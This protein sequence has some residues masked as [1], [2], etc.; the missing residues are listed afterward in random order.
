[1][2]IGKY[3]RKLNFLLLN[4]KG[5]ALVLVAFF[6]FVIMGIAAITVDAGS[7]YKTRREMVNAADAAALAGA[8]AYLES[9]GDPSADATSAA[10]TFASNNGAESGLITPVIKT[11]VYNGSPRLVIEVTAGKNNKHSFAQ[12]IGLGDNMDVKAKATATWGFIKE[13]NGGDVLP[14]FVTDNYYAIDAYHPLHDGKLIVDGDIV[15]G[16][17]GFFDI[18]QGD[19]WKDALKGASVDVNL[20][21]D[22]PEEDMN[23]NKQALIGCIEERMDNTAR[24]LTSMTGLVP[25]IDYDKITVHGSTLTLPILFFAYYEI[26]DIIVSDKNDVGTGST[27]ADCDLNTS[28]PAITYPGAENV[29]GTII[30]HFTNQTADIDEVIR[31]DD[32]TNPNPGGATPANYIK[33]IE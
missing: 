11:E 1:M 3:V 28:T 27:H 22:N 24:G 2:K 31:A 14:L 7:L 18:G 29:K 33:L 30:G 4:E 13:I 12:V 32:Q 16:N 23:G 21:I 8:K 25:V 10:L 6:M 15:G 20:S 5:A 9:T 26:D 17:W 19:T